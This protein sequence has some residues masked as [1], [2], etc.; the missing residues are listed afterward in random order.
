MLCVKP[1]TSCSF[2][3]PQRIQ[4]HLG[5]VKW[6]EKPS[7]LVA[8]EGFRIFAVELVHGTTICLYKN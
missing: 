1:E 2:K 7:V 4:I 6:L 5:D 3:K 8:V